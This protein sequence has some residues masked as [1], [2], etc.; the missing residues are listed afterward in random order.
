MANLKS[1]SFVAEHGSWQLDLSPLAS[2]S[3]LERI[4]TRGSL[5]DADLSPLRDFKQLTA[6]S[7]QI[8]NTVSDFTFLSDLTK[9]QK[10]ELQIDHMSR[11]DFSHAADC[12]ELTDVV[13]ACRDFV[14]ASS[15]SDCSK[16]KSL[17]I[18]PLKS[19][20]DYN[21]PKHDPWANLIGQNRLRW[22]GRCHTYCVKL[23]AS[24]SIR[25][26][27]LSENHLEIQ[28]LNC[29]YWVDFVKGISESEL[30]DFSQIQECSNLERINLQMNGLLFIDLEPL[31]KIRRTGSK[32]L[33]SVDL[34]YNKLIA[35]STG[36]Y[37][38][39]SN[40]VFFG[41]MTY[42]TEDNSAVAYRYWQAYEEC[43]SI[44]P[45]TEDFLLWM[46]REWAK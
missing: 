41:G 44:Y 32:P 24:E 12:A 4:E 25:F 15:L 34:T 22:G 33:P 38:P 36:V 18:G 39:F 29:P 19:F 28:H 10:L 14:D 20:Y 26:L 13:L 6:L 2:H 5:K 8:R 3:N 11:V 1:F 46:D 37:S 9:L 21:W 35:V 30:L 27:D 42:E 23:P 7:M 43:Q 40:R 16:L 17:K 45:L 31:S